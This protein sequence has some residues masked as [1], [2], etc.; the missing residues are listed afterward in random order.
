MPASSSNAAWA[1]PQR[2]V[3]REQRQV[4]VSTPRPRRD[5][6]TRYD[7][8]SIF[9]CIVISAGIL[10]FI[11]MQSAQI[12]RINYRISSL[13]QQAR[14]VE[15]ENAALTKDVDELKRPAR[16][17][18]IALNQLHMKY[19]DPVQISGNTGGQ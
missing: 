6:F 2:E 17:L 15:A 7:R 14:Q 4:A 16:I 3:H 18:S 19:A 10:W 8:I 11:A 13:Q 12:D 1:A 9:A 5:R